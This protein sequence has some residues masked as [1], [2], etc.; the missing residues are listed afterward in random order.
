MTDRSDIAII[1][2]GAGGGVVFGSLASG[3][4]IVPW[5]SGL[6]VIPISVLHSIAKVNKNSPVTSSRFGNG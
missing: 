2:S 5:V 6:S 3:W 1:G 4:L